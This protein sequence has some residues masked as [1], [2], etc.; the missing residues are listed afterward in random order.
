[1]TRLDH[2]TASGEVS[3]YTYHANLVYIFDPYGRNPGMSRHT[4]NKLMRWA[5]KLS[6]CLYVIE[7]LPGERHV[8]ADLLT[9]WAVKPGIIVKCIKLVT[10]FY[11][12]ITTETK[13]KYDWSTSS[14][15][16]KARRE[17]KE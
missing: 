12:P 16:Y 2:F 6:A 10:L 3:L 8:W 9:R 15:F 4:A 1:M 17:T 14:D 7:H 13:T 11:A 5:L